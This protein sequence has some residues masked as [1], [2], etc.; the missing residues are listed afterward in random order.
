MHRNSIGTTTKDTY[1]KRIDPYTPH[2]SIYQLGH[3]KKITGFSSSACI[4]KWQP[5][6]FGCKFFLEIG[7]LVSFCVTVVTTGSYFKKFSPQ[8]G[9][10]FHQRSTWE[11]GPG[12]PRDFWD[13]ADIFKSYESMAYH[14]LLACICLMKAYTG[15]FQCGCSP[16]M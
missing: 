2:R 5:H 15:L 11:V 9:R 4:Q 13:L 8:Q 10:F 6:F 12:P 7:S 1:S 16:F 3:I 14:I